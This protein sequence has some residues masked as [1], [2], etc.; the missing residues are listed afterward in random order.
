MICIHGVYIYKCVCVK[1]L[2]I[3]SRIA[4]VQSRGVCQLKIHVCIQYI[5]VCACVCACVCVCV[6]VCLGVCVCVCACVCV[7]VYVCVCVCV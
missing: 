7:C 3:G 5:Y 4:R 1:F 2:S 6:Y